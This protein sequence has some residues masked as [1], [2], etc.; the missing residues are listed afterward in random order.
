[1]DQHANNYRLIAYQH[2]EPT[3][4]IKGNELVWN[5]NLHE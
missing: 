2:D 3:Q 4:Q 5:N 1:M